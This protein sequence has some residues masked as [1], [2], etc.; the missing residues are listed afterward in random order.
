MKQLLIESSPAVDTTKSGVGYYTEALIKSIDDFWPRDIQI[1]GYYFNFLSRRAKKTP[2]TKYVQF[3]AVR[4]VPGTV[5]SLCRKLNFQPPLELFLPIKGGA[6]LFTNYVSLPTWRKKILVVYDLGFLDH[7][8][9]LQEKNLRFLRRFSPRSIQRADLIVTISE[10]TRERLLWHFPE[11]EN[12]ILVTPIPPQPKPTGGC[13]LNDRL[14]KLGIKEGG[15]FLY[16]GTIEPRKNIVRLMRAYSLLPK[17]I[18]QKYTLVLAGGKGWKDEEIYSTIAQLRQSGNQIITTGYVSDQERN[19]LYNNA[20]C[21]VLPSTYEGFGMPILEAMQFNT[22]VA[23][24]DIPVFREVAGKAAYYFDP[25]SLESIS[26]ALQQ[27]SLSSELRKKLAKKGASQ[28]KKFSWHEN[29]N[30][31]YEKV[32]PL[33]NS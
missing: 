18:R 9:H 24:S 2:A 14:V 16:L 3:R 25:L 17:A 23:I 13:Q 4:L 5:L 8:E 15:Y 22:P 1:V 28:L 21:F 10:F 20:V 29:A 19:A 6:V 27:I 12:R 11:V 26:N 32:A 33:I 31:L 30:L 7:P